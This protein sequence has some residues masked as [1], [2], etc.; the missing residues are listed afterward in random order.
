MS[1]RTTFLLVVLI[2]IGAIAWWHF[3]PWEYMGWWGE[4]GCQSALKNAGIWPKGCGPKPPKP[5]EE[6]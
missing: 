2:I 1:Q 4:L 5:C 3:T 6:Q